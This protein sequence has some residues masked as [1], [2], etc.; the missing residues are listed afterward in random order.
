VRFADDFIL[1]FQY[2]SDAERV[3]EVLRKRFAKYGL[4]LHPDKT[5]LIEFGREAVEKAERPGGKPP[6]TFDFLGLTH[7]ATRSRKGYFAIHVRTMRKRLR[8]SLKAANEWC[9]EHRHLPL[10]TQQASLNRK[11]LGHY[12][13]YGRRTNFK[14]LSR[15]YWTVLRMW[16]KSL[17]RRTRGKTMTWERF[18]YILARYPLKLP[19]I[20][21]TQTRVASRT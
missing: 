12:Q 1:C 17:N 16:K 10:E 18:R 2:K 3:L 4:T 11:L 6:E 20:T 5:R 7:V 8:R 14:S 13:Y 9:K 19:R 15:F 21:Q